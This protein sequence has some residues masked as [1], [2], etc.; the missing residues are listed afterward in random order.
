MLLGQPSNSGGTHFD[1]GTLTLYGPASTLVRLYA[2]TSLRHAGRHDKEGPT[3]PHMQPLPG[4][5]HIRFSPIRVR[6]PLL[7]ESLLFSLPVGTEMFHFPTFPPPGLCVQPGVTRHVVRGSPIRKSWSQRPVIDS[8]RLIADSHVLHR[9]L[10]PRHPPCALRNFHTH[11]SP[12]MS[13]YLTKM[14]FS[15]SPPRST[16][17]PR[18]MTT[19]SN[20]KNKMLAST[21]QFSNNSPHPT[22]RTPTRATL[23]K[24]EETTKPHTPK[25][26]RAPAV[27][28]PNSVPTPA[29]SHQPH[30][31]QPHK[32]VLTSSRHHHWHHFL[33]FHP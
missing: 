12:Q 5:T 31:F 10:L 7:T 22:P 4:I 33:M 28:G 6:S 18:G 32:G 27:P 24:G 21:I 25:R 15:A 2:R 17:P 11:E 3:T 1:Y 23:H 16:Q 29:R 13:N 14:S 8:T 9:L 19:R 26:C 20:D 30:A